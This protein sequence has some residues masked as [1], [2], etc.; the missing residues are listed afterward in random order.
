LGIVGFLF[1]LFLT[2]YTLATILDNRDM[3]SKMYMSNQHFDIKQYYIVKLTR[4]GIK[5][6]MSFLQMYFYIYKVK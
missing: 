5:K 1:I 3:K 6:E 4:E 2:Y